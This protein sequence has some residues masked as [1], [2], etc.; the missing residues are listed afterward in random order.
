VKIIFQGVVKS[1]EH[2][3][4]QEV[5][6]RLARIEE[7]QDAR[8]EMDDQR[9]CAIESDIEE[10]KANKTWLWRTVVGLA[11]LAAWEFFKGHIKF[12]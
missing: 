9:F 11:I 6:V 4:Q 5:L 8:R 10:M 12:T 1:V 3:F 2:E 7:K